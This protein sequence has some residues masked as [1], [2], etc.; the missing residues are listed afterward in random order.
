M[1]TDNTYACEFFCPDSET[2]HPLKY[3][4]SVRTTP[5]TEVDPLH[6]LIRVH[7]LAKKPATVDELADKFKTQFPGR[8]TLAC[9]RWGVKVT[10]K[11]DGTGL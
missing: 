2:G 3:T 1:S 11:R 5:P 7:Q 6:L 9:V 4:F 10:A 8:H